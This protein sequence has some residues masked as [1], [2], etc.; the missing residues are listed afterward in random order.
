MKGN[1]H[2]KLLLCDHHFSNIDHTQSFTCFFKI[3]NWPSGINR[4]FRESIYSAFS[5]ALK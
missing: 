5:I 3:N 1:K 4:S 2:E